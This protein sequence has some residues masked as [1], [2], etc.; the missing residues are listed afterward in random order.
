MGL[1]IK[2]LPSEGDIYWD[3]AETW[4]PER[5]RRFQLRRLQRV[6]QHAYHHLPFYRHRFEEAAFHPSQL[7][8][9]EDMVK[10]PTFTKGEVLQLLER[11]GSFPLG[12]EMMEE[13]RARGL[14]AAL[15]MTSGTVGEMLF[16]TSKSWVRCRGDQMR[17]LWWAG[18]RPGMRVLVPAPGWHSL[19]FVL[20]QA[21]TRLG[22]D[23]IIPW[24]TFLPTFAPHYVDALLKHRP[25]FVYLFLPMLYALLAE[26]RRRGLAPGQAFRGVRLVQVVGEPMTPRARERL[27]QEL[28]VED[29]FE[30]AGSPEGL[31]AQE[32]SFHRGHHLYVHDCYV[33]IVDLDSERPL[34]RGKRGR[35]ILTSLADLSASLYIRCDT[36]DIA[37]FLPQDCPCGRTW[38]LIEV[39]GRVTDMV[40]VGG[41]R[42]LHYDVRQALEE[43]P[44]LVG[45][46]FALVGGTSSPSLRVVLERPSVPREKV[47]LEELAGRLRER[48]QV[49]VEVK[50]SDQLPVRWKGVKVIQET[51][52]WERLP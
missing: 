42:I 20:N 34:G 39:Y 47:P 36:Q 6:I 43:M 51:E 5:I 28:G 41:K 38:P 50:F 32:C 40:A 9:L 35:L 4:A 44:P 3:E 7:K 48:F 52:L 30:G 19:S 10:V 2:G 29:I 18:W 22:A 17:T 26:C 12:M 21:L 11:R 31:A 46:P 23:V 33:E 15:S 45:A 49:P 16:Y 14:G 1:R 37:A 25:E 24:G 27:R 8:G 13:G